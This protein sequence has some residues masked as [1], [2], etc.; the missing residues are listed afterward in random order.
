MAPSQ[1]HFSFFGFKL[2]KVPNIFK[3][4]CAR[5]SLFTSLLTQ[6]FLLA[7]RSANSLEMYPRKK[8]IPKFN[9]RMVISPSLCIAS[10]EEKVK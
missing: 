1:I 8:Y 10:E 4:V 5:L 2:K 7:C 6:I 3:F 9:V